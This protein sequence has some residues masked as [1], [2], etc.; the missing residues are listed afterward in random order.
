MRSCDATMLAVTWRC[1]KS[2]CALQTTVPAPPGSNEFAPQR[3][4]SRMDFENRLKA[5][6]FPTAIM[7]DASPTVEQASSSEDVVV[8]NEPYHD[9]PSEENEAGNESAPL[10]PSSPSHEEQRSEK[11]VRLLT[12]LSLVFGVCAVVLAI[13]TLILCEISEPCE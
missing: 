4:T 3:T 11:A 12:K 13:A 10:M 6:R 7:A 8:P 2:R 5:A 1:N 9:E